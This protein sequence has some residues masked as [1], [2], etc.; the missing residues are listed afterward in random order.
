VRAEIVIEASSRAQEMSKA[1]SHVS[2]DRKMWG[3]DADNLA[4]DRCGK[5]VDANGMRCLLVATPIAISKDA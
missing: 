2:Y 4:V 1:E 3:V 5:G